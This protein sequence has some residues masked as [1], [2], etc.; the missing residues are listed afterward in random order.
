MNS[1]MNKYYEN[2]SKMSRVDKN[3]DL[4]RNINDVGIDDY[5]PNNNA[6]VLG[7]QG[8]DIN[9]EQ[10]KKIVDDNYQNV[11]Q[12][13][14]A[15]IKMEEEYVPRQS[16]V[17]ESSTKEYD[18]NSFLAKAKDGK[19]ETYE[20]ARA[21]KLRD[22]QF[23]IL[24]N[25]NLNVDKEEV[26]EA[27]DDED[28]DIAKLIE[29]INKDDNLTDNKEAS[30]DDP[31]D[32]F[33]DL[34]GSDDTEIIKGLKEELANIEKDKPKPIVTSSIEEEKMDKSFYNDFDIFK[35]NDIIQNENAEEK[36]GIWV[37]L[38]IIV[39]VIVFLTGLFL[40]LKT[41]LEF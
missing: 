11:P 5:E 23:D 13:R 24:N 18:I 30:D 33:P 28:I 38:L 7:K 15:P 20:E 39:L 21:K 26:K 25:L 12:R 29:D 3:E 17:P 41:L 14:K 19:E 31:L 32:M 4:Y 34:K 1:R 35:K 10:I 6:T 36:L 27:D 37:K 8:K 2:S 22:T 40:F 16:I 9:L